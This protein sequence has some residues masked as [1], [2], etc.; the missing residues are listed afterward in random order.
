MSKV[1]PKGGGPQLHRICPGLV[2]LCSNRVGASSSRHIRISGLLRRTTSLLHFLDSLRSMWQTVLS[3]NTEPR[4]IQR[5]PWST[6]LRFKSGMT[7]STKK[8]RCIAFREYGV[9]YYSPSSLAGRCTVLGM[10]ARS[11]WKYPSLS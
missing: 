7:M 11:T 1:N 4:F 10:M 2:P 6:G 8:G 3:S 9:R 5:C